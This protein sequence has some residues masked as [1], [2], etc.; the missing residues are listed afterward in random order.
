MNIVTDNKDLDVIIPIS[1]ELDAPT[2]ESVFSEIL[3]QNE[4]YGFTRFALAAPC[5]GWRSYQYPPKSHFIERATMF[6]E[7]KNRLM[8]MLRH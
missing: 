1:L 6:A 3:E 4:R 5:G 7:I 2:K 8:P